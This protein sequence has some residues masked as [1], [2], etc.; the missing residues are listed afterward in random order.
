MSPITINIYRNIP[1]IKIT[2]MLHLPQTRELSDMLR[3]FLNAGRRH[4]IVDMSELDGLQTAGLAALPAG[5]HQLEAHGGRLFLV[6]PKTTLR[7][8]FDTGHA[9]KFLTLFESL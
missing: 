8:L 4:I 5:A 6:M 9:E 7:N 3:Y 1:I 2:G